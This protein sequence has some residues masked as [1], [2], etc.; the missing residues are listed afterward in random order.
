MLVIVPYQTLSLRLRQRK[1]GV[2]WYLLLTQASVRR[3]PEKSSPKSLAVDL[4][5]PNSLLVLDRPSSGGTVSACHIDLAESGG[6]LRAVG[7]W[8]GHPSAKGLPSA[9]GHFGEVGI[10]ASFQLDLRAKSSQTGL[11]FRGSGNPGVIC[12]AGYQV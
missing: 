2:K 6:D 7:F 5:S 1:R 3:N 4:L 10:Q 8:C 11:G 9:A 12:T